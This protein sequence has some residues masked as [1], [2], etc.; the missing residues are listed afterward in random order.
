MLN[1]QKGQTLLTVMLIS[2]VFTVLGLTIAAGTIGGTK[3]TE[4]RVDDIQLTAQATRKLN[5]VIADFRDSVSDIKLTGSN[6]I[7]QVH[8]ELRTINNSLLDKEGKLTITDESEASG[9]KDPS[10]VLTKAYN[11]SYT[12]TDGNL[13][14]TVSKKVFLSPTPTFLNFAAGTG[15]GLDEYGNDEV[16]KGI[17]E[18]NGA[19]EF[20]GNIYTK[21]LKTKDT[22]RYVDEEAALNNTTA[23]TQTRYPKL[24]G[25]ATIRKSINGKDILSDYSVL[26]GYFEEGSKVTFRKD[27]EDYIPVDFEQTLAKVLNT[28]SGTADY[29][30]EDITVKKINQALSSLNFCST[31]ITGCTLQVDDGFSQLLED[32]NG[33]GE[34]IPENVIYSPSAKLEDPFTIDSDFL[35]ADEKWLIV[36]GNLTITADTDKPI[37]VAGN[38]F[39][40]GDLIIEGN[41]TNS[42]GGTEAAEDDEVQVDSTIYVLGET[43]ISNT[44]IKGLDDK[45]LVVMSKENLFMS[46]I[47]EFKDYQQSEAID[48]FLFTEQSA[49]LYGVG[50][51]FKINGGVFAEKKLTINAIR[52]DRISRSKRL[53]DQISTP[54]YQKGQKS[55]FYVE[56]DPSVLIDQ[57]D[58]LPRVETYQVI[59]D[60]TIISR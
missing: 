23:E 3:R 22:A 38:I 21:E 24:D 39:V 28:V 30:K 50:S 15:D 53:A 52:Q 2:L 10:S 7:T 32:L 1:N 42:A 57:M 14:K 58:A 25:T 36:N 59:L 37:K 29:V 47:N 35:L 49:E 16:D 13:T 9:I 8:A 12:D 33:A 55:R 5:E 40:T 56:H 44:N 51:I 18:L 4:I 27:T 19:S 46:R 43:S 31:P 48:A 26:K 45:Q 60:D 41:Q 6:Q 17:M 54:S 20:K 11:F 34:P